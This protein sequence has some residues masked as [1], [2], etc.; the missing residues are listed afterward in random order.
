MNY[1][2]T[3]NFIHSFKGN[4]RRPQ[5]ERM[6]WLLKQAGDPQSHYPT[7]HIVGTNGKGSTTSYLQNILTKSG[8]RVGT[9]TS[10]YI[11]R[12]NE[13]ISI[14]G[15]E[16]P[17][18]DL[19]SLVAKAQ[20][21]LNDLEEH[22]DFERPTEF[23][24]VTLLMFLYFNLKQVDIAIIEA[25]IGGRLDST[26]VLSPELVICT[27]IGFDHTETLGN[28]LLD[29]ANHKAGIMRENTPILLGRVSTEVEHF[30]NQKS[31]DLQA[32]LAV[33]DREIQ[34]LSKDDQT[35][36][37]SY[38]HWE[39]PNLKLPMLGQHQENNAGLAVTA[40]HLLAQTFPKITDKSIQEG[41]EETH[42]PGRSEWIGNNIYLDGAHNPQGIASLKQ[43]LKDN[44]A[45]RRV[46]ILFAGL[47][48][49]PLADLLEELKDYD[50]TVTSFDFFEA[51]PLDDYPKD[52]KRAADYRDWLA[53]AESANS[54]D[55]FVVTG[56]LYFISAVRNYLIK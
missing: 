51:L 49:K 6:R 12:F 21:L 3:L 22:T 45:N 14:N 10:P 35:I 33:I 5:L 41:I 50:I 56:S 24:L 28:S 18:K 38:D 31:H 25:G 2:E 7:V 27:S 39:S 4:G 30:F 36:Q 53:Q 44:F 1:T 43:V 20:V 55:L 47:R 37:I 11:T 19:I 9:F 32:P 16:I 29:I 23:E 13:R 54:D 26:N 42:W 40:A 52:F 46:H 17:D 48:R 15:T 34:L 8:Y